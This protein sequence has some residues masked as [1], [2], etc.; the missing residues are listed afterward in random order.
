MVPPRV[1]CHGLKNVAEGELLMQIQRVW[2]YSSIKD[3]GPPLTTE[4]LDILI[5]T[6]NDV[7]SETRRVLGVVEKKYS[8]DGPTCNYTTHPATTKTVFKPSAVSAFFTGFTLG[9]SHLCGAN[10]ET[11]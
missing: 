7:F 8:F 9:I 4:E 1:K 11:V 10:D 3:S 5:K 2:L 6:Y